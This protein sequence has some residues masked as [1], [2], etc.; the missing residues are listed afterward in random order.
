[1]YAHL[2]SECC[3]QFICAEGTVPQGLKRLV[4]NYKVI[5]SVSGLF[6]SL[7]L[8]FVPLSFIKTSNQRERTPSLYTSLNIYMEQV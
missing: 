1:M 3:S 8:I 5:D 2:L 4:H 6:S 7:N